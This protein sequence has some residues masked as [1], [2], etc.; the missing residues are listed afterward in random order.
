MRAAGEEVRLSFSASL[1]RAFDEGPLHRYVVTEQSV[2]RVAT[3]RAAGQDAEVVRWPL[4]G[5]CVDLQGRQPS[6]FTPEGGMSISVDPRMPVRTLGEV[7]R[8]VGRGQLHDGRPQGPSS[9][10][11]AFDADGQLWQ[12]SVRFVCWQPR[13]RNPDP[14]DTTAPLE[15]GHPGVV[16]D[17]S[18]QDVGVSWVGVESHLA[19][20]GAV[21][22]TRDL[23]QVD[24]VEFAHAV[25][26]RSDR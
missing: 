18:W 5:V 3:P 13:E 6:L 9:S 2:W 24:A 12:E 10:A 25:L 11:E 20:V 15:I 1:G 21:Y 14:D 19:S 4:D 16:T 17:P 23:R 7:I 26:R 22:D 8:E